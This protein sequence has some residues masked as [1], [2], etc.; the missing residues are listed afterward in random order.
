MVYCNICGTAVPE[1]ATNCPVCGSYM[2]TQAAAPPQPQA[3]PQPQANPYSAPPQPT[4]QVNPYSQQPGQYSNQ[5]PYSP[6]GTY[7]VQ[8]VTPVQPM[9][10]GPVPT[11][12]NKMASDAK[13]LGIVALVA[14]FFLPLAAWI[15]GGIGMSKANQCILMAQAGADPYLLNTAES[16]K[17]LCLAGIIVG[18]V[19]AVLVMMFYIVMFA[20]GMA[21]SML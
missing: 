16:A 18:V 10:G 3:Q 19:R 15:C 20:M 11:D 17:K 8:P 9:P 21:D 5:N 12:P 7:V 1:N 14:A 13:T 4:P 6:S 2:N